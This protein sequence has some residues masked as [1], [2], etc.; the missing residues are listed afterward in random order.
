VRSRRLRRLVPDPE[1]FRRRAAG[2]TLRALASDYG[3]RHTTLS[4]FFSS[5]EARRQLRQAGQLLRGERRVAQARRRD[6]RRFEREVRRKAKEQAAFEREQARRGR[7]ARAKIAARCDR[8]QCR[9]AVWLDEQDLRRPLTRADLYSQNDR[10]AARVVAAGG[11][12]AVIEATG[13]RT[14]EN[15]LGLI[16][17]AIL[18]QAVQNDKQADQ[19]DATPAATEPAE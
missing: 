7:A 6:Q 3:V 15:L 11:I 9:Y 10:K 17:P 13:L 12:E 1:L 18:K 19:N 4:R 14:R 8:P 2:E 5:P 16:D